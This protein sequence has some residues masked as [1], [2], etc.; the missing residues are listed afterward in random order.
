ML[1]SKV[2]VLQVKMQESST[3]P[4]G[5][6]ILSWRIS[7]ELTVICQDV[8][9]SLGISPSN[10]GNKV[11]ALI[12]KKTNTVKL[13]NLLQDFVIFFHCKHFMCH[14]ICKLIS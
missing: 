11:K 13:H 1:S 12:G 10:M 5:S 6:V 2:E 9:K 7:L 8:N 14:L 4:I 3:F